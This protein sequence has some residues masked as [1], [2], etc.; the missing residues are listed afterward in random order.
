MVNWLKTV[1]LINM[2]TEQPR[3]ED[4]IIQR[5]ID[6]KTLSF[7]LP[8]YDGHKKTLSFYIKSVDSALDWIENK[9]IIIIA[10]FTQ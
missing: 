5:E 10:Y 4:A 8:S 1:Q 9:Q 2:A 7:F 6:Y 3:T